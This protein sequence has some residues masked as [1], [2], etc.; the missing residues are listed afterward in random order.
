MLSPTPPTSAA[1]P[2]IGFREF[3]ALMAALMGISALGIDSMLPALG[4]IARALS[5][6]DKNQQQWI[7]SCYMMGFGATQIIYGPLS[8]RYGRRPIMLVSLLLYVATSLIAS[9]ATTFTLMIVARTL[10]GMAAAASRVLVVSMVRDC[11]SGREMARVMSLTFIVFLAVPV[12]APSIGTMILLVAPWE[13]IFHALALFTAAVAV[14][15]AVRLGETQ[16]PEYRQPINFAR[17]VSAARLVVTDRCSLG[18]TLALTLLFGAMMGFITSSQQL[19]ADVFH[20]PHLFPL[21]F[22]CIAGSMAVASYVNSRIVVRLGTRRV[23]HMALL[24]YIAISALHIVSVLII[25][26]TMISFALFQFI[27]MFCYGLTSSNFSAMAMDP[28]GHIAGTASSVQGTVSTLGGTLVGVIIGQ[29]F[30]FTALPIVAGFF[31]S[32]ICALVVVLVAERGK[33][34]QPQ[35]AP[36]PTGQ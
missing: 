19:F 33:L 7:L 29:S 36:I 6:T 2:A 17:I 13:A 16:H 10:Q 9:M 18:Y 28:M 20:Q 26:D 31:V 32:G 5:L 25:G 1:R 14:W 15:L 4:E 21:V 24:G 11:Y 8:D 12:L 22:A 30:N 3:V 35:H 34:F 23:S 27:L